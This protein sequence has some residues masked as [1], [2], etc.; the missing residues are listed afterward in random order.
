[1]RD[2]LAQLVKRDAP[3]LLWLVMGISALLSVCIGFIWTNHVEYVDRR[4][5]SLESRADAAD[6]KLEK[7]EN[8]ITSTENGQRELRGLTDDQEARLRAVTTAVD[9]LQSRH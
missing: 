7:R 5:A 2:V 6:D 8:R 1:M 4:F 9:R 3:L